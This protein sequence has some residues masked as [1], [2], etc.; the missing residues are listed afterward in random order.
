MKWFIPAKTFLVGEYAAVAGE[1][2]ILL[3]TSPC[4]E[5]SFTENNTMQ[6][7]H[8]D[9]P[10]GQ[11]WSHHRIDSCGLH[12]EDPYQGLGGLGASSA[13][14]LGAYLASC[15]ALQ[16]TP[17][18]SALLDAYYQCAWNGEGLK[19]SGYDMISQSQNRCVYIHKE[20]KKVECYDW[21]FKDIAF[22]L[23]H[24]GQ[25]LAT[26]Y[27]LRRAALPPLA[28]LVATVQQARRAFLRINSEKLI[29]AINQ[30]Q[31]QLEAFSLV[32]PHTIR[33]VNDFRRSKDI[34][35]AKGC[36]ALG[37]DVLLLIVPGTCLSEKME[38]LGREGWT[39]L[40]TSDNLYRDCPVM[41]NK[42]HKTLEILP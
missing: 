1:P 36:G 6:G 22:L 21:V 32:A 34:L 9:S 30:Y 35:A 16:V 4:F 13:Q 11:W 12:W 8:P 10:A 20:Q 31:K 24:S 7:I 27:H 26:H 23:V 28:Q 37:S 17:D 19:P 3:T 5:L 39:V 2:A 29:C 14:F 15:H 33:Y 25:K 40:A 42:P 38:S 18:Y 41:K